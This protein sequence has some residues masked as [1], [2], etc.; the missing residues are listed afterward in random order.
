MVQA[1]VALA[2]GSSA[3]NALLHSCRLNAFGGEAYGEDAIVESFRR[4]PIAF[5]AKAE[6]IETVDQLALF[7][8]GT[9]VFAEFS[10][11]GIARLWRVGAATP[12]SLEPRIDVPFDPCLT[13]A[14]SDVAF[15]AS[16]HYGLTA[17]AGARVL[18]IGRSIMRDQ[19]G[20]AVANRA[21][22][23]VLR[24]FGDEHR[25]AA[26]FAVHR[27]G[28]DQVRSAG[29]GIVAALWSGDTF[30]SV[31]DIAGEAAVAAMPWSPVVAEA[32]DPIFPSLDIPS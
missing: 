8:G 29:F 2:S 15:A 24:A 30:H 5:S 32:A 12:A 25:G 18:A 14:V 4:Q 11:S 9:G 23:F 7:E 3:N 26:L 20:G 19:S 1:L 16:D 6:C 27:L 22:A 28:G 21:R 17:A 31:R 10:A 13:Q